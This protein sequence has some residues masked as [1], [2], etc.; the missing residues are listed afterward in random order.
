MSERL[1]YLKDQ[2]EK[3]RQELVSQALER[4]F[5]MET[6]ELRK[7][8]THFMIAGCQLER[9]KQLMDKKS[10]LE[11]Q[12]V[13]EQVYAKLWMIDHSKKMARE[14]REAQLKRDKVQETVNILNW[15][16]NER[17][18]ATV[19]EADKKKR[20]QEM[21]KTQWAKEIEADK[22][23]E[24]QKFVLNR[25]RNLELIKHNA[26]ERELRNIQSQEEKD[27]DKELLVA[28]LKKEK[29]LADIEEAERL[30][31]RAEVISLQKYYKQSQSD[32]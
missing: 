11:Q 3:E 4:K 31:R 23:A 32:K 22:E 21:L 14:E 10:K 9:E 17:Q 20:E 24:R 1:N 30:K 16:T 5:K 27:R 19:G 13:E 28:A 18:H 2:R 25:E 8:E 12:I 6:D 7:E 15:Q 29:D 26:A